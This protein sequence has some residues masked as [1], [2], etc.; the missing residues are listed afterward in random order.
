MFQVG[1]P[2]KGTT[3][4]ST[5][6]GKLTTQSASRGSS[7]AHAEHPYEKNS[8]TLMGPLVFANGLSTIRKLLPSSR[9]SSVGP[10]VMDIPKATTAAATTATASTTSLRMRFKRLSSARSREPLCFAI[11]CLLFFDMPR[12]VRHSRARHHVAHFARPQAQKRDLPGPLPWAPRIHP[13]PC[14]D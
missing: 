3:S 12:A 6:S 13:A 9:A 2:T 8:V 5:S 11:N 7:C 1:L 4:N 14:A 10:L